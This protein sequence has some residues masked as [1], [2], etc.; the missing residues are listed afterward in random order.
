[1][2]KKTYVMPDSVYGTPTFPLEWN[3]LNWLQQLPKTT[4]FA[5]W[6]NLPSCGPHEIN[7]PLGH[8]LYVITF[9]QETLDSDWLLEQTSRIGAPIIVLCDESMYDFPLP[10]NVYVYKYYSRHHHVDQIIQWFPERQ[11]RNV[12]YKISN[13]CNRITQSKL[14]IFTALMQH[15]PIEDL[16]VKLGDWIE[17]KNVH[18]WQ[19]TGN[20]TL[21]CLTDI[22]KNQYLTKTIKVDNFDNHHDNVQS[23]N[24]NPWNPF[25]TESALHFVS[26]SYH[27]SLMHTNHGKF[28][29]PGPTFSE[30]TYK[31]LVAGTP[32]IPVGQF[33]S[34]K[35][36]AD[37][38][39]KFNYGDLDLSWDNDPGNLTRLIGIVK[40][41]ES[42][43]EYSVQDILD[44][45]RE[46][47][48]HNT[49]Y[50]WSGKLKKTCQ[51]H[52]E[53]TANKILNRFR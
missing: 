43:K 7:L 16:L 28:I 14:I 11:P 40:L 12:K 24:S 21:D 49:D 19:P 33:E 45:T 30:K 34:Y 5:L 47:T 20:Q 6:V 38:G 46:S 4:Y 9:H 2:I 39:L 53:K 31:C 48:E 1:M 52:N 25:Y 26:E 23:I 44:I 13:I 27:Y 41:I 17:L 42:L 32:F 22:F 8:P 29:R 3:E 18:H 37:L 51:E 36:L 15:H 35:H 50:I 10:K